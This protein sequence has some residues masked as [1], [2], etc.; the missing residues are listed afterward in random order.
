M[1]RHA[2]PGHVN[3]SW[4]LSISCQPI[5]I[6]DQLRSSSSQNW[7]GGREMERQLLMTKNQCNWPV[8]KKKRHI[9]VP[10]NYYCV[11]VIREGDWFTFFFGRVIKKYSNKLCAATSKPTPSTRPIYTPGDVSTKQ[12][13]SKQSVITWSR[14]RGRVDCGAVRLIDQ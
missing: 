7:I 12:E 14:N 11:L 9:R 1:N 2:I 8:I 4:F 10:V 5:L 6:L 3:D 13:F